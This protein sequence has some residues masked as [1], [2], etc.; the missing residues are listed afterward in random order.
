MNPATQPMSPAVIVGI[1]IA[2]FVVILGL[3]I[4]IRAINSKFEVKPT[5]A[6]VAILPV[7]IFLLVIGKIGKV[8]LGGLTIEMAFVKASTSVIASQVTPLTGLSEPIQIDPKLGVGEIPHLIERKTQG[9]LFRLGS[10]GY[11]NGPAIREYL[12]LLSKQPF[13]R[14]VIIENRDKTFF[15]MADARGLADLLSSTNPPDPADQF[16]NWLNSSDKESL[17]RLP[18]YISS[19]SAVT[20]TT[21]KDQ[22]LRVMESANIDTLPVVDNDKRFVGI[23]NRSRLT[24]SLILDVAQQLKK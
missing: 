4:L 13:L 18:G 3:L 5:D 6:V 16:A 9:L 11:Y 22:A 7:V 23:V 17:K 12:I 1:S 15:A 21:D 10:V 24:A 8:A 20:E 19:E 14:Y 2:A